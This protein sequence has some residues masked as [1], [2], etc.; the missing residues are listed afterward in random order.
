MIKE[1][2]TSFIQ[3]TTE[4]RSLGFRLNEDDFTIGKYLSHNVYGHTGYTG[5]EFIID[6]ENQLEIVA[7]TNRV[8]YTRD[9][10][11]ITRFRIGLNKIIKSILCF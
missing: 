7:F 4:R 2:Q 1:E 10:D 8:F 5:T 3:N 11:K 9:I 6:E